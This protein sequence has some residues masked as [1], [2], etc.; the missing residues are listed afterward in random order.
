MPISATVRPYVVRFLNPVTKRIAPWLPGFCTVTYVG[1]KTGRT[2]TIPLNVFRRGPSYVFALTYGP[3]VQ[4][5]QNVL[6]AGRCAIVTRGRQLV[7]VNP[8]LERDAKASAMPVPVRQ[9]LRVMDVDHFLR[10]DVAPREPAAS[11][12][13]A[14]GPPM[15]T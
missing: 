9:F 1:R 2:Y 15:G 13:T 7:L 3:D 14:A 12:P 8:R 10:M 11:P 4:W 5:V 6:A